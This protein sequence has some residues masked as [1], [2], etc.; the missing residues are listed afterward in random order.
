[1]SE[2]FY[3]KIIK[4]SKV[5]SQY[6]D[7]INEKI[8]E[9]ILLSEIDDFDENII[10]IIKFLQYDFNFSNEKSPMRNLLSE[11]YGDII[12]VSKSRLFFL[13]KICNKFDFE[14]YNDIL[15]YYYLCYG[16]EDL[17]EIIFS[18]N[19][20]D[21]NFLYGINPFR[22]ALILKRFR[23][24]RWIYTNNV[25]IYGNILTNIHDNNDE[26]YTLSISDE[27]MRDWIINIDGL[28]TDINYIFKMAFLQPQ[29]EPILKDVIYIYNMG[30][31]NFDDTILFQKFCR[32]GDLEGV[33]WIINNSNYYYFNFDMGFYRAVANGHLNIVN[34][35][36]ELNNGR[37]YNQYCEIVFC[38]VRSPKEDEKMKN[39]LFEWANS[40]IDFDWKLRSEQIVQRNNVLEVEDYDDDAIN[41]PVYSIK[42][43]N[44]NTYFIDDEHLE[45]WETDHNWV[46]FPNLN[47]QNYISKKEYWEKLSNKFWERKNP[48]R[49]INEAIINGYHNVLKFLIDVNILS[50]P[51]RYLF[52]HAIYSENVFTF[53][54]IW[55]FLQDDTKDKIKNEFFSGF[56]DD[57][58]SI[59][60]ESKDEFD[61][62]NFDSLHLD[63]TLYK[64]FIN[65]VLKKVNID[66][67][68]I[69]VQL[70]SECYKGNLENVKWLLSIKTDFDFID[71]NDC[72]SNSLCNKK[73]DVS[74]LIVSLN[75]V[76]FNNLYD[77][78]FSGKFIEDAD[79]DFC[80]WIYNNFYQYLDIADLYVN[81]ARYNKI[82]LI[83]IFRNVQNIFYNDNYAFTEACY[84]GSL[85]TA[86]WIHSWNPNVVNV[87]PRN[88]IQKIS[89][90]SLFDILFFL[91]EYFNYENCFD[92]LIISL[93]YRNMMMAIY[94]FEIFFYKHDSES[95][96]V[97]FCLKMFNKNDNYFKTI[98]IYNKPF[99][100]NEFKLFYY[101]LDININNYPDLKEILLELLSKDNRD[102]RDFLIS[103]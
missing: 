6:F 65:S 32:L 4:D 35:L 76:D 43:G 64:E 1:M 33:N 14:Q 24:A 38:N 31:T 29:S 56:L 51:Y 42:I 94:C 5:L 27:Y 85:D 101:N 99:N 61:N 40:N 80:I 69:S 70:R 54:L 93:M 16:F 46:V 47:P 84:Y 30:V 77:F 75:K 34:R 59:D 82:I 57:N 45:K 28:I 71:Y 44:E 25:K 72:F 86:I 8:Y 52:R 95:I 11:L 60:D 83:K 91:S 87:L 63:N 81:A 48:S 55:N 68:F 10:N 97:N 17:C 9:D 90:D 88:L 39:Y 7:L 13:L 15:T 62:K 50:I 36:Y 12:T 2:K 66:N 79:Y 18:R 20:I 92:L 37:I 103:V 19:E 21:T 98:D 26:Y 73:K 100:L 41:T 78:T 74:E 58:G 89:K 67:D 22:N 49:F 102:I 23:L 53:D 3:V 96:F